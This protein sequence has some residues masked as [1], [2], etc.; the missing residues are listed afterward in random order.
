VTLNR[1]RQGFGSLP[2]PAALLLFGYIIYIGIAYYFQIDNYPITSTYLALTYAWS[3]AC[4]ILGRKVLLTSLDTWTGILI[5]IIGLGYISNSGINSQLILVILLGLNYA[6][7]RH[8]RYAHLPKLFKCITAVGILALAI[9]VPELPKFFGSWQ[10][11]AMRPEL[12]GGGGYAS[13]FGHSMGLLLVVVVGWWLPHTRTK[14]IPYLLVL[15][16]SLTIIYSSARIAIVSCAI[17]LVV[18]LSCRASMP[19]KKKVFI[20][21]F[22]GVLALVTWAALPETYREFNSL[23]EDSGLI[24]LLT[25]P[26][27]TGDTLDVQSDASDFTT[28]NTLGTRVQ[29]IRSCLV[30]FFKYPIFGYGPNTIIIPHNSF[31]Q[32]LFEHGAIAGMILGYTLLK[33]LFLTFRSIR[34]AGESSRRD[35]VLLLAMFIYML[36]YSAVMGSTLTMAS[37]FLLMG[38]IVSAVTN[39]GTAT[40]TSNKGGRKSWIGERKAAAVGC[41]PRRA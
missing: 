39:A 9:S 28:Q 27:G 25:E 40:V 8:I 36:L 31:L 22:W 20:M 38:V 32:V 18:L 37:L 11:G 3:I 15:V 4:I 10:M 35:L 34:V 12:Y 1:N 29:I 14:F 6:I 7:G 21:T 26:I 30:Q 24:S 33:I 16:L 19:L 41:R 2:I 5:A 17:A 23:E 13:A